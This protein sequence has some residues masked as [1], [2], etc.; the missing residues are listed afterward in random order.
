M[1]VTFPLFRISQPTVNLFKAQVAGLL[2]E[3][4]VLHGLKY[5]EQSGVNYKLTNVRSYAS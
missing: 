1:D 5:K 3:C 2:K 4:K